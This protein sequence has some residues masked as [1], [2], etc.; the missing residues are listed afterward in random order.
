MKRSD[1]VKKLISVIEKELPFVKGQKRS[2]TVMA[3]LKTI[4][5]VGM[6]PPHNGLD[7]GTSGNVWEPE[8]EKK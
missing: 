2:N 5:E 7:Y 6:L 4:E 3:V 8:N 1:F